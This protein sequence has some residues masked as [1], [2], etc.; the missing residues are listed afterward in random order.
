MFAL[1]APATQLAVA[2]LKAAAAAAASQQNFS[3]A[4]AVEAAGNIAACIQAGALLMNSCEIPDRG[5]VA[6]PEAAATH[7]LLNRHIKR[8][9]KALHLGDS[10]NEEDEEEEEEA[11]PPVSSPQFGQLALIMLAVQ[12]QL[13]MQ[14]HCPALAG[15][16]SAGSSSSSGSSGTQPPQTAA[17][18]ASLAVQH[19]LQLWQDLQLARPMLTQ[20]AVAAR[21]AAIWTPREGFLAAAVAVI[22][23]LEL[24]TNA[25]AADLSTQQ[26]QLATMAMRVPLLLMDVAERACSSL[27]VSSSSS[28][29]Y[30]GFD[31]KA[32]DTY[33]GSA[34]GSCAGT[35]FQTAKHM[36]FVEAVV[37]A[38]KL[39]IKC[40]RLLGTASS[41]GT[42]GSSRVAAAGNSLAAATGHSSALY[43]QLDECW[44]TLLQQLVHLMRSLLKPPPVADEPA[45][46]AAAESPA[47][48]VA[49]ETASTPQQGSAL[50]GN[51]PSSSSSSSEQG[52][53]EEAAAGAAA[54][55]LAACLDRLKAVG[56]LV[57]LLNSTA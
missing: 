10:L 19:H 51:A 22:E 44:E 30:G 20:A 36:L 15:T 34:M 18:A 2:G 54:A 28:S 27:G 7:H 53:Q 9:G 55:K 57:S 41:S 5:H 11:A 26:Q 12:T 39:A 17:A 47:A 31:K 38:V 33:L 49:V 13:L 14:E 24:L 25:T 46:A 50:P 52:R 43:A 48:A 8:L 45:A 42:A 37:D 29:T 32:V 56:S 3:A 6:V 1:T 4:R 21:K 16:A 35:G 23:Q 40:W